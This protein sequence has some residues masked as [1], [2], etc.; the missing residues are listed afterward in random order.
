[1]STYN[2]Q[3]GS[4]GWSKT[5]EYIG[6]DPRSASSYEDGFGTWYRRDFLEKYHWSRSYVNNT[7]LRQRIKSAT[8]MCVPGYS[9]NSRGPAPFMTSTGV[10]V[11]VLGYGCTWRI[12]GY[13][14]GGTSFS[15]TPCYM[16]N[17]PSPN[18]SAYGRAPNTSTTDMFATDF[19]HPA[20]YSGDLAVHK[21]T[22][23]FPDTIPYIEPGQRLFIQLIPEQWNS[24]STSANTLL[25]FTPH[26]N[27]FSAEME[28]KPSNFIWRFN[29]KTNKSGN[30]IGWERILPVWTFVNGQWIIND[31]RKQK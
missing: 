25:K 9:G 8:F 2:G 22:V 29:S 1:M 10:S 27:G 28:D 21:V 15:S 31:G 7:K 6:S 17:T 19:G 20:F 11:P 26:G 14:Q 30:V 5:I 13:I 3:V 23:T 12:Y 4:D 18:S 24:G 16:K